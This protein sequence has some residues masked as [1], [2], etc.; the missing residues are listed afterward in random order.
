M[1]IR[2]TVCL[3]TDVIAEA[4]RLAAR[5]GTLSRSAVVEKALRLMVRKLREEEIARSVDAYYSGQS[6]AERAEEASLVAAFRRL[7]R[8]LDIDRD[9]A[10]GLPRARR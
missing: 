7:R 1:K 6:S 3:Q 5:R 9:A 2:V 10:T 8:N 4:E